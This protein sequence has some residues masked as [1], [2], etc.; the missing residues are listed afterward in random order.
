MRASK[1]A[2]KVNSF[3]QEKRITK[4]DLQI[5]GREIEEDDLQQFISNWDQLEM[6]FVILEE[7][8]EIDIRK[9]YDFSTLEAHAVERIRIFGS[10]GDLDIRRDAYLFRWRYIG[11]NKLPEDV[12]GDDFWNKN[13]N[14]KFF[15][16]EK[17]ALLWGKYNS[18]RNLWHDNR[19]AKAKLSY[20]IDGNPER[21]KIRYRTLSEEGVI[22]FV[23]FVAIEGGEED[24]Q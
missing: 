20:P 2:D 6:P 19:V 14:K 3:L 1:F 9:N 4:D 15:M 11:K 16:E 5:W 13:S 10:G 7:V 12:K 18:D 22:A 23:W 8:R 24:E 21:V 17:E